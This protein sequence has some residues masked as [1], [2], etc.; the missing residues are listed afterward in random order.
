MFRIYF[1]DKEI[2]K[3]KISNRGIS[4]KDCTYYFSCV[5]MT[6]KYIYALCWDIS[7]RDIGTNNSKFPKIYVLDRKGNPVSIFLLDKPIS[8]FCIFEK[9]NVIFGI[10]PNNELKVPLIRY[11]IPV[12]V[13]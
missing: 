2:P 4:T 6:N 3:M 1:Q 9:E 7:N 11:K 13:I 10:N 5:Q 8:T 12:E